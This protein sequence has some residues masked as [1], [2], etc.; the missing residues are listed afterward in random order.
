MHFF[1]VNNNYYINCNLF[2]AYYRLD[3]LSFQF[4]SLVNFVFTREEIYRAAQGRMFDGNNLDNYE[5]MLNVSVYDWMSVINR[6]G[7]AS[8]YCFSA[9]IRLQWIGDPIRTFKPDSI[10]EATVSAYLIVHWWLKNL[11]GVF[12][13]ILL[14]MENV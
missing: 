2:W 6:T 5:F 8:S 14:A 10:I 12:K 4:D 9:Q 13:H 3:L 1:L 11:D 7:W